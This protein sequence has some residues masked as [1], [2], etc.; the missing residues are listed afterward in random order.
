MTKDEKK[1][2]ENRIARASDLERR[3]GYL[4]DALKKLNSGDVVSILIPFT[5]GARLHYSTEKARPEGMQQICWS[6]TEI[7]LGAEIMA[8]VKKNLARRLADA[9][10]EY[11]A[12]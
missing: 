3:I 8:E 5:P 10:S 12:L 7:G 9:E 2:I 6:D 4:L 1:E 11:A